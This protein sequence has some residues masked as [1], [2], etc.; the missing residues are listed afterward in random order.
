MIVMNPVAN[1]L[2]FS[3]SN[4]P[5]YGLSEVSSLKRIAIAVCEEIKV[6]LSLL[7]LSQM[8]KHFT[9][10]HEMKEFT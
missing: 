2:I 6:E 10:L 8:L 4:T 5:I 7:R 1:V 9:V 3:A